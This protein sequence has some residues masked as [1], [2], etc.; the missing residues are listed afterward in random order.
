MIVGLIS[1]MMFIGIALFAEVNSAGG[2]I[3][4]SNG[5]ALLLNLLFYIS[6]A[7]LG[8]SFSGLYK[9]NSYITNGTFDPIYQASYWIRFFWV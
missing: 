5:W 4:Q 3:L 6:A 7:R 2:N 9:A 1:L 8:A